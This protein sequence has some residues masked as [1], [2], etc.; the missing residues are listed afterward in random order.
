MSFFEQYAMGIPLLV[1]SQR[2]LAEWAVDYGFV[3][4][5]TWGGVFGHRCPLAYVCI[6]VSMYVCKC[7][8]NFQ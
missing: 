1:P 3:F 7:V 8:C 2:L 5:R 4:Q 6:Y